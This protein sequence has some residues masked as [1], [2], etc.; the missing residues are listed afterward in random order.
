MIVD[1]TDRDFD[2]V[3][4][5]SSVPVT[6]PSM[7][8]GD[9]LH[10]DEGRRWFAQHLDRRRQLNG[11]ILSYAE[12]KGLAALDLFTATAEPV[13]QQL[14]A[15]CSNDGLH[16]NTAGYRQFAQLLYDQVFAKAFPRVQE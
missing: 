13:T 15:W 10:S 3:V 11:M 1:V 8:G 14:A 16:L 4:E 7:K 12:L 5:Q 9:D 2:S 6:V